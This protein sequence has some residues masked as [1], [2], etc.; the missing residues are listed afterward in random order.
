MPTA[1]SHTFDSYYRKSRDPCNIQTASLRYAIQRCCCCIQKASLLI[2]PHN[3]QNLLK[4]FCDNVT[5]ELYNGIYLEK[6]AD[7]RTRMNLR[8]HSWNQQNE[9]ETEMRPSGAEKD[10]IKWKTLEWVKRN[11]CERSFCDVKNKERWNKWLWRF[12][13]VI[14]KWVLRAGTLEGSKEWFDRVTEQY[15]I[16]IEAIRAVQ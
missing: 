8:W 16:T 2:C 5:I 9:N 3:R 15:N 6:A 12:R 13:N 7:S 11:E 10:W 1:A 4:R 14:R